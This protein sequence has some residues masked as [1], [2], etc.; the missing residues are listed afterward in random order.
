MRVGTMRRRAKLASRFPPV[1]NRC[2]PS[3]GLAAPVG[4]G[5]APAMAAN[6]LWC[7]GASCGWSSRLR[8]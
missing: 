8:R 5:L 4:S 1:L 2:V 3:V 7:L 6:E